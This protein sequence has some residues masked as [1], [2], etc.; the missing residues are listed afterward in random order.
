[1]TLP[2]ALARAINNGIVVVP[3]IPGEK[4]PLVKWRKY[5]EAP[6]TAEQV[7]RWYEKFPKAVWAM[8]CG[9]ISGY[10]VL[11]FDDVE[12]MKRFPELKPMVQTP[13]GGYH[14]WVRWPGFAIVGGARV[15]PRLPGL[16]IRS[17]GHLATFYGSGYRKLR[18]GSV[19]RLERLPAPLRDLL[20][21]R[22]RRPAPDLGVSLPE[23]FTDYADK[24]E[25]LDEALALIESGGGRNDTGFHLACQLRDERYSFESAWVMMK[26]FAQRVT[27]M[28]GAHPYTLQ[29]AYNSLVQ[30]YHVPARL[31]RALDPKRG[32][33][34][35]TILR[36]TIFRDRA[37]QVLRSMK[38]GRFELSTYVGEQEVT[39][40]EWTIEGLQ[41]R[42]SN[43]LV[44]GVRKVGKTTFGL[45]LAKSL[46]DGSLFLG[47]FKVAELD[48]NL[49]YW[50]YE[51]GSRQF[52]VW[53]R[54]MRIKRHM[55]FVHWPLR[56]Q[57]VDIMDDE[58]FA[59]LAKQLADHDIAYLIVD[60][61]WRAIA[62]VA[63]EN[64]NA[65]VG[66]FLGRLDALKNAAGITD[67]AII[68]HAGKKGEEIARGASGL[69][70]WADVLW[71]L[72]RTGSDR[73]FSAEGRD[74]D[75][76]GAALDYDE[77]IFTWGGSKAEAILDG[78]INQVIEVVKANPGI[79]YK[80][81]ER[82][83]T[84][85][86][87]NLKTRAIRTAKER[88]WVDARQHP[89]HRQRMQYFVASDK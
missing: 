40:V 77:G 71:N 39:E 87:N 36:E 32:E 53:V 14:V 4:A 34:F 28:N 8:I 47:N 69:E 25:L 22:R 16:D 1:M 15:D 85:I 19:H 6:P 21:T 82:Q 46:L 12:T 27:D 88:G 81:I 73:W 66:A 29:E 18:T 33:R 84:Q 59:F 10:D 86:D 76:E 83:L 11:D 38:L 57:H 23:E 2:A 41:P 44:T 3:Q 42:G 56:G 64:S 75:V 74:V 65:E 52:N 78:A 51:M 61:W 58:V 67:M 55:N 24:N 80:E 7:E 54:R 79:G 63:D 89:T 17:E 5:Q 30:A 20:E 68:A 43:V 70:G 45:N 9:E 50:N 49:G 48:G 13:S 35:N 60:P 26:R 62:G 31:P 72:T 37:S